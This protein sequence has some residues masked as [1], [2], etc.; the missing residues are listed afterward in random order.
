MSNFWPKRPEAKG[1][2]I[3]KLAKTYRNRM[4]KKNTNELQS[5]PVLN[6]ISDSKETKEELTQ[7]CSLSK[8]WANRYFDEYREAS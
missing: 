7:N 4:S 3:E 5:Y 6:F 8:H 1:F 2:S